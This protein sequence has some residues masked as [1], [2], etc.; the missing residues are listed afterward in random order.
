MR[1]QLTQHKSQKAVEAD[2]PIE[3]LSLYRQLREWY[4]EA[5]ALVVPRDQPLRAHE[6]LGA[7]DRVAR[8][9]R[10]ESEVCD[11]RTGMHQQGQSSTKMDAQYNNSDPWKPHTISEQPCASRNAAEFAPRVLQQ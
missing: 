11:T 3:F 7:D 4:G 10:S 8:I 9:K 5:D 6:R 1:R 2:Y